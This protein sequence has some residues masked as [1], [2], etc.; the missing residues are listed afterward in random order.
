MRHPTDTKV[1]PVHHA[2]RAPV[3]YLP[4]YLH[5]EPLRVVRALWRMRK[6]AGCRSVLRRFFADLVR[7]P[8][9][10]R[11]RR[12]GQAFVLA[13]ELP[14]GTTQ[15]HA[16]FIHTPASVASYAAG[17]SGLVWS[18][19]AHAKDIWTSPDWDLRQKL[20]TSTFTVTC[21]A[22]GQARLQSLASPDRP[23]TLVYHGLH[24]D[25]FRPLA[26]TPSGRDGCNAQDPVR[27]LSVGRA[28]EKKGFDVLLEALARLPPG[29]AW[30]LTHI[31]GGNGLA[32]LKRKAV[33]LGLDA[34][35][36]WRGAQD[37]MAVLEACRQ[38][39]LFVLPSRVAANGDRDGLPNV[40]VEAQSQSLAC[41]STTVAGVM[42]L[43]EDG[44]NGVLVPPD[45]PDALAG[46]LAG[47]IAEPERRARLGRAGLTHV[48]ERLDSRQ[49]TAA[50]MRLFE[51]EPH[52][53]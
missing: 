21:T 40:L 20:A 2:I 34:R 45:D 49:A 28:V 46:A 29:L 8:S 19:S 53:A 7:D 11:V 4:E 17:L 18:C 42:E 6:A 3:S 10:N 13:H 50:L 5:R 44:R 47:L 38:A 48:Q 16:H 36:T 12:L 25:R 52:H 41:L 26:P 32:A 35:I 51:A 14:P 1:H 39:D 23:V 43:I 30:S 22:A 33:A 37:Q 15:I 31:G 9:R 24:L 27:L